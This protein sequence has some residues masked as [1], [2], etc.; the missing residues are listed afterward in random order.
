[1]SMRPKSESDTHMH[2]DKGMVCAD[3][4]QR[5]Y[6]QIDHMLRSITRPT[7]SSRRDLVFD[8]LIDTPHFTRLVVVV[9]LMLMRI[10]Q[11]V[12]EKEKKGVKYTRAHAR[13]FPA[14][15]KDEIAGV[16]KQIS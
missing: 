11:G 2:G 14:P 4:Q 3:K 9:R 13:T 8:A 12:N 5:V 6:P 15:K 10:K 16:S 7:P 1:M